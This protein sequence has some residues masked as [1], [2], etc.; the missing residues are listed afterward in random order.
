MVHDLTHE[1]QEATTGIQREHQLAI[2]DSEN[3]IRATQHMNLGPQGEIRAKDKQIADSQ[4]HCVGYLASE[5]KNNG[6]TIIPK[7][8]EAADDPYIS[9]HGQH[10]YRRHKTRVLLAHNQGST[11]FAEGDTPYAII[12]YNF[13]QEHRLI[14]VDPNRPRHFRLDMIN[15]EQLLALS[16][17]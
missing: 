14:V 12:T 7:S 3:Q 6:V 9:I 17:T 16:N 1:H 5:D 11:L 10:G 8:N 15:R 2:T 4:R 13:W